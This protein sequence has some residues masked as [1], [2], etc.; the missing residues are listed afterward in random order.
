MSNC[1]NKLGG[2]E[3]KYLQMEPFQLGKLHTFVVS[4]VMYIISSSAG[5]EGE[6][7]LTLVNAVEL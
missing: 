1:A 6:S 3:R 7:R 4:K 2:G 5:G